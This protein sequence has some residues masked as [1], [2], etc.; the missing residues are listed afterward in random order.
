MQAAV[1]VDDLTDF[2]ETII[3]CVY[4]QLFLCVFLIKIQ[5]YP[6]LRNFPSISLVSHCNALHMPLD[7]LKITALKAGLCDTACGMT[8]MFIPLLDF[9]T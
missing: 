9:S 3:I 1:T 7:S 6:D 5:V 8:Y 4:A 2:S